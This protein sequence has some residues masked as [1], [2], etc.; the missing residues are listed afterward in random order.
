MQRLLR[1]LLTA[2][3][4]FAIAVFALNTSLFTERAP[5]EPVLLA[6]RGVAQRHDGSPV[7]RDDC[8]ATRIVPPTHDFLENTLPSMHASVAAGA[9][10]IE[11]DVHPTSD[12][13]FVVFHDWTLD[14]RT[15]GHGVTREQP[16]SYLKA[17]D[18]GYGYTADGGR[19]FPL[20]G[21]GVGLM[22][23]LDEVLAEFPSQRLLINVK[24]RDPQ[25]GVKL[26]G[27]LNALPAQR[28]AQLM[29]YGDAAPIDAL[30]R[31][32]PDVRVFSRESLEACLKRYIATG[33]F[34]LMPEACR[35]T[36]VLVPINV[37]PW[38]W[39][40]PDRFM[41]RF[42]DVRSEVF[43]LGP[44]HGGGFSTGLDSAEDLARLPEGFSGGVWT[45]EIELVG[46]TLKPRGRH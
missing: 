38:L 7:G 42:K 44:Y 15:N 14:C 34:G 24:S 40:W 39:G 25:E 30:R 2:L 35:H 28:R 26:A 22:P 6:H 43:V 27:V 1:I 11:L 21:K 19:S 5:G 23:T 32:A 37:A 4:V 3:A 13:T 33:W 36:V 18:V 31:L 17:L 20:R 41:N 9:D 46:K 16:L 10:V 45:N 12:G 29:A 8:T